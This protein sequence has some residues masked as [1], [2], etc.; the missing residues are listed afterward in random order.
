MSILENYNL[1]DKYSKILENTIAENK[2]K[3]NY[4]LI[5]LLIDFALAGYGFYS[6]DDDIIKIAIVLTAP[7]SLVVFWF[8]EIK[9]FFDVKNLHAKQIKEE[10]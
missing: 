8:W 3:L 6:R 10:K 4:V 9:Y 5:L 7:L 2:K 1:N